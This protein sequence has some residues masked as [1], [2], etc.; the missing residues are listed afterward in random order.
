MLFTLRLMFRYKTC[1]S[2]VQLCS[3]CVASVQDMWTKTHDINPASV[4]EPDSD[5]NLDDN[6]ALLSVQS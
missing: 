1:Y 2:P 6:Y 3:Q 4:Q 5:A